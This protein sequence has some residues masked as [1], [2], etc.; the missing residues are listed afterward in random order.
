[1]NRSLKRKLLVCSAVLALLAGGA[2]TA[3]TAAGEGPL[4]N[5]SH[6]GAKHGRSSQRHRARSAITVAA[7][8]LGLSASQ[9][10]S[11]LRSGRTLAQIANATSGKSA[12]GLTQAL[13]ASGKARLAAAS[14]RLSRRVA[15]ELNGGVGAPH[16]SSRVASYLGLSTS[17]LRSELSSGRTLAQIADSTSGKSGAGLIETLV[18]ARKARLTARVHAGKL[19]PEQENAILARVAKRLTARVHAVHSQHRASRSPTG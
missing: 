8:Y 5:G 1:M 18:A 4:A 15:R 12:A 7:G 6:A 19:T 14:A 13:L 17:Q 10:Q 16:G 3:V 9:L 11:E 2:L